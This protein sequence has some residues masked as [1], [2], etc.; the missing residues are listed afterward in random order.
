MFGVNPIG[1]NEDN[2]KSAIEQIG[3]FDSDLGGTV[4]F[5]PTDDAF[6]TKVE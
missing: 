6:N 1:Y 3:D 4:L 5:G 2:K